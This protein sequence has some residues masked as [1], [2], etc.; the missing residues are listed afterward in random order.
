VT[1][2]LYGPNGSAFVFSPQ[3]GASRMEVERLDTMLR[4]LTRRL[5]W[6]DYAN[7]PGAGA[8]GGIAVGF[9][10]M[11]GATTRS[12][13]DL[14]MDAVKLRERIARADLVVTGEGKL[15]RQSVEGK[16]V[17]GVARLCRELGK[18]CVAIAGVIDDR[19]STKSLGLHAMIS[20]VDESTTLEDAM[21]NAAAL[22]ES[23]AASYFRSPTP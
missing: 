15:D 3:K 13:I 20:L 11:F 17:S 5:K 14:V 18:P 7:Q 21:K 12:G 10:A 2:P 8:A 19:E 6:G 23:R 9:K 4:D 16:T 1:N 22:V